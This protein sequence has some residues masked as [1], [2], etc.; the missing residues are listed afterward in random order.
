MKKV[1]IIILVIGI[2][3]TVF[4]GVNFLTKEKVLDVGE[5][6]IS[7]TNEHSLDWS[8]FVGVAVIL[9]GGGLYLYS[10]TKE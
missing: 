1:G 7:K 3:I 2:L 10:N 5:I 4:T 9:L 6:E 8:P